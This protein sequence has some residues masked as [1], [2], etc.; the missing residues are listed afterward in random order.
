MLYLQDDPWLEHDV[1]DSVKERLLVDTS[2]G[3][4]DYDFVLP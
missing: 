1:I 3:V 4:V 2:S